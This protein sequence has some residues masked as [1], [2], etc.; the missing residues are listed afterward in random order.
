MRCQK[1]IIFLIVFILTL[2]SKTDLSNNVEASVSKNHEHHTIT[3]YVK[4]RNKRISNSVASQIA[5]EII[6]NSKNHNIRHSLLV[7]LIQVESNFVVKAKGANG[8]RGLMQVM[9]LWV[10]PLD[11]NHS[12]D[13]YD[14][15]ININSGTRV[16]KRYMNQ[17]N[18]CLD[19]ALTRYV[20]GNP[21]YKKKVYKAE[22]QFKNFQTRYKNRKEYRS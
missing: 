9:P 17:K 6:I 20:G 13:L 4:H 7:G 3:S 14:V 16:L 18:G 21:S 15:K 8:A 5:H 12:H 2:F 10:K 11:L 22:S 19:K 1:N